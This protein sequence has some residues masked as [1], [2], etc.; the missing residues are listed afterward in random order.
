MEDI[1][2]VSDESTCVICGENLSFYSIGKCNHK[3]ICYYCTIKNRLFYDDIKCPLCNANLDI[4]YICPTSEEKTFEELSQN[5]LS[6]YYKIE[7]DSKDLGI[8]YTDVSSYEAALQLNAYKCPIEYCL[9]TEPF[10]TYEELANHLYLN[11]Q[12][13]YCKVCIKDGKKFISEQKVYDKS[14]IK[15]HNL[16]G[17]LEEE[18]PPHHFCPFCKDLF[19]NDE[20]LYKHMNT[21][22]FM[23]E[24]CKSMNKTILFYSALPNLIQHNKLYHYC[25]PF[26]D[27]KDVLYVAFGTKKKLIEHFETKHNQKNNNL[28]EQMAEENMPEIIQD[29]TFYDVSLKKDEFDFNDYIQKVN[30]RCIQHREN[31]FKNEINE[32]ESN[33]KNITKDGIEIIY[34]NA[35]Q[36]DYKNKNYSN[37]ENK[38]HWENK[39]RNNN[40]MRGRGRGRGRGHLRKMLGNN[41]YLDLHHI[42]EN[43]NKY[44]THSDEEE[45]DEE[46]SK[47]NYLISINSFLE[48]IKKYIVERIK[49]KKIS[50]KEITLPKETQY[51]IIVVIDKIN[52]YEKILELFNIQIFGLDWDKINKMKEYLKKYEIIKES[53]LF[54]E[55]DSL[56]L[57]NVLVLYKYLFIAYKKIYGEFFKLEMEQID[58]NLYQNFIGDLQKEENKN[59]KLN[60]YQNKSYYAFNLQQNLND[61]KEK[62][63]K[64]HHKNKFKWNQK[65]IPGLNDFE[66]K[67]PKTKK[68]KEEEMKK[69]F[70]KFIK[71]CKKEDE[72]LEKEKEKNK[73]KENKDEHEHEHEPIK[74]NNNKSK[75]AMLIGS[76]EKNTKNNNNKKKVQTKGGFKL[77]AFN[78]D[79]DF[80]PLK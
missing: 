51:Q 13:F 14:E 3:E 11:H 40:Y 29:P 64:K 38:N 65:I 1:K 56:T 67:K 71:E 12:K 31:K 36:N 4:V 57:K 18:I 21:S 5:D 27:C 78:L 49:E 42:K 58:E 6:S 55:F 2:K 10:E 26:K 7:E 23:C 8:Y 70:D 34:T 75:L 15:E 59:K 9:K 74:K 44:E 19:Y 43:F 20:I 79:E 32:E 17:D 54:S 37:L 25:C 52:D 46:N 48:F 45:E 24:I 61:V 72:K 68:S 66:Q 33:G 50:L 28:N 73:E 69:N 63:N 53:E 47:Q 77:S 60:G 62:K 76:N 35:P 22:H 16:Y 30:K 80:P 39:N 41:Y